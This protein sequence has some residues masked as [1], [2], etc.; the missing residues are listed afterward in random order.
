M[1]MR[2]MFTVNRKPKRFEYTPR[3]YKPETPKPGTDIKFKR[4][5]RRGTTRPIML[6]ALLLFLML[7]FLAYIADRF[8]V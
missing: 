1:K 4:L 7:Y 5:T 3:Y 8:N 2:S 6:Y